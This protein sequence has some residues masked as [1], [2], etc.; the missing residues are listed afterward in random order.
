ML[1]SLSLGH[2][3]PTLENLETIPSL[4]FHCSYTIQGLICSSLGKYILFGL[5]HSFLPLP[6]LQT[7][8]RVTIICTKNKI[9]SKTFPCCQLGK[10]SLLVFVCQTL[11]FLVLN[12]ISKY[13]SKFTSILVPWK[14]FS[15]PVL[16]FPAFITILQ[17]II[18]HYFCL[19]KTFP[20]F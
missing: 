9:C 2:H 19:L 18:L 17:K 15:K 5:L 20:I 7:G 16:F 12:H 1:P 11:S 13:H 10:F 4:H 14:Q 3:N 8:T 6:I